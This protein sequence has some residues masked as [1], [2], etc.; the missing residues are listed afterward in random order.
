MKM[1]QRVSC[2]LLA[3]LLCTGPVPAFGQATTRRATAIPKVVFK[4]VK[5]KNGLRVLLV[6]DH[7]AP[8]IS[9]ALIYDVGSRNERAG[10]TGF[11]HLFEHMMFQGS[12]NVGKSEHFIVL[13]TNGGQM[14]GT[15]NEERTLYF[16]QLPSNQLDLL[17]FLEA[18]RMKSLDISQENLDNQRK[19]VQEERRL[20]LD[21]QPYGQMQEKFGETMYDNFAYKH[22]VIGSMA[23]LNAATV[24]DVREFFRVYYAPNNAVLALVGDFNTEQALAKVKAAFESIPAQP[25]PPPVDTK[26]PEQTAERRFTVDDPLARLTLVSIGYKGVRGNTPDAY[27]LQIAASVL[28]AGQSSRLYQKLVKEKQ[29]AVQVGSFAGSRRGPAAFQ[30]QALIAQGKKPE[31][32]E[33]VIYEE[34]A[35]LQQEPI[36]DWELEKAKQFLKRGAINQ[37]Q[38]SLGLAIN[39]AEAAVAWNDPDLLNTRL[40]KQLAVTKED[41]QRVAKQYLQPSKRTVGVAL[42]KPQGPAGAGAN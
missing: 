22:S 7:K 29:L 21:N 5:L 14:N 6:E 18:D 1:I 26:E 33:S 9:L 19:A 32:V 25:A 34:I 10:R 38:S 17:L 12:Q 20:G 35:R 30:F 37:V 23:D 41:V 27:A 28:G 31:E 11:A 42:P 3:A 4:D 2:M 36:A 15:T 8:V 16:E 24:D 13:E 39:L 40:S